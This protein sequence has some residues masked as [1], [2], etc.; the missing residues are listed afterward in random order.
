MF[1]R[2]SS[3]QLAPP[4]GRAI[5]DLHFTFLI[6]AVGH[7]FFDEIR[8]QKFTSRFWPAM[9]VF[10]HQQLFIIFSTQ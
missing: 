6:K 7:C 8:I 1:L 3:F 2:E 10:I 5:V 9:F 4:W